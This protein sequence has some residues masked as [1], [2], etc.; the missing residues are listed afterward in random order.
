MR[1]R[2]WI[3]CLGM[4]IVE[5]AKGA[6]ELVPPSEY[7]MNHL[8]PRIPLLAPRMRAYQAFGVRFDDIATTTIMLGTEILR[9]TELSIGGNSAVGRNCLLDC[10]GETSEGEVR[11][12]RNVNIGSQAALVAGKHDVNSSTFEG[13][14]GPITIGDYAWIS[15]RATVLGD[16]TIGEGAVVAAGAVVTSDVA[17]YTIVGGVPARPIG[18][19]SREL[20]YELLYRP[21]WR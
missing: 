13:I 8:V 11:I 9:P 5:I 3:P 21:N 6:R 10:R 17:P 7:V 12:G 18:E 16:V 4:R 15:F 1:P 2:A 20:D 19:R 14:A